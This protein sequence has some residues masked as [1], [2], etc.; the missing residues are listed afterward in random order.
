MKKKFLLIL[1]LLLLPTRVFAAVGCDL[2]DPDR[3]VKR[4]FPMSTGYKTEYLTIERTGGKVLLSEVEKRLG[5]NFQGIFE[6]IDV[7]YTIY[8]IFKDDQKI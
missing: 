3:D 2:N 4:F 1:F 8:T 6:T 5:D 7:P